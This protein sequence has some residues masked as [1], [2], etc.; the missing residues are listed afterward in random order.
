PPRRHYGGFSKVRPKWS[1]L[2]LFFFFTQRTRKKKLFKKTHLIFHILTSIKGPK[3]TP[4]WR[5]WPQEREGKQKNCAP[6]Q[7][8][9][10][11][12]GRVTM[13]AYARG[14][15]PEAPVHL[16]DLAKTD[17]LAPTAHQPYAIAVDPHGKLYWQTNAIDGDHV[18]AILTEQV[19]SD[20]LSFLQDQGV[21]Y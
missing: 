20:Y 18:V 5:V 7:T 8:H 6:Y 17:F 3:S 12:C 21:S 11:L 13:A 1:G 14:T 9:A 16:S 10:Q 4:A 15:A 2:G 19:S